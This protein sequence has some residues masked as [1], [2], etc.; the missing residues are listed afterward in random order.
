MQKLCTGR[1]R[2]VD[3]YSLTKR[4]WSF[5]DIYQQEKTSKQRIFK[6]YQ[7]QLGIS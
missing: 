4:L 6:G 2:A 3:N 1:K 7:Q 5:V